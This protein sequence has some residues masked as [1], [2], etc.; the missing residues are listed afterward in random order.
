MKPDSQQVLT[1]HFLPPNAKTNGL[2]AVFS[3]C[4]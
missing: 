3:T 4:A 2:R 1:V